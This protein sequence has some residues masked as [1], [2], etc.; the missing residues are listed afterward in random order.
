MEYEH[1][2]EGRLGPTGDLSHS[3]LLIE[4]GSKLVGATARITALLHLATYPKTFHR[5][6]IAEGA[7]GNSL[8]RSPS[9]T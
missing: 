2:V 4:W 9:T 3:P 5:Q 1:E 8:R 6:A 7:V